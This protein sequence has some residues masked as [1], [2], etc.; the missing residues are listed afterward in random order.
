M[1]ERAEVGEPVMRSQLERAP[2][3]VKP[4]GLHRW[5]RGHH[6]V[7]KVART[8]ADLAGAQDVSREHLQAALGWRLEEG[9]GDGRLAA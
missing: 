6:R 4:P 5:Q 8:I 9:A 1:G 7:V 2:G 3:G